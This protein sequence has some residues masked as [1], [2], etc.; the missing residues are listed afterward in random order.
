MKNETNTEPGFS[1][2]TSAK[3]EPALL[4]LFKDGIMDIYWAENHLVKNLPKMIR[5]ATS[6]ELVKTIEDHLE[7]TKGHVSRLEQVFGL[8]DE[9]PLAKKCDAMEGLTKEGEGII[10]STES[11]TSTRDVGIILASQKVEHYEIA[12]YGGLTQLAQTLGLDDVAQLLYQTLAEEK[13]A[14]QLLTVVAENNINY[15]A[16]EEA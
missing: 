1:T 10:E 14:D 15:K 4:E 7:Q 3:E 8:L 16:S 12:T 11:G 9:K 6:A 2:K 13:A 5:A